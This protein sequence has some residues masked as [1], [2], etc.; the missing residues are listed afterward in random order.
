MSE[1]RPHILCVGGGW[2]A[3][4]LVRSLRPA[5]W[6]GKADLTVISRENYV[7]SHGLVAEMLTGKIQPQQLISPA[8]RVFRPARFINAEVER[9]DLK[10]QN[11]HVTRTLDGHAFEVPYDHLVLGIGAVDDLSRY[12]GIAEHSLRLKTYWDMFK[13]RG[14]L[15]KLLESAELE[16]DHEARRR[17]LTVVIA[18]GNYAGVELACELADFFRVMS[19]TDYRLIDPSDARVVIVHSGKRILPE[20]RERS[21]GLVRF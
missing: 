5:L 20:L 13:A 8:R 7:T 3:V 9:I 21:P 17:L 6:T 1:A 18:G 10:A 2:V 4:K 12:P 14:R 11:L 15:S 16:T 19:R